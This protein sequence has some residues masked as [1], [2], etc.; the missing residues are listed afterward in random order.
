MSG[1]DDDKDY[2]MSYPGDQMI[3]A[4]LDLKIGKG[5]SIQGVDGD[6]KGRILKYLG[7]MIDCTRRRIELNEDCGRVDGCGE[8]K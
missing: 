4:G 6:N 7:I 5:E 8:R 3:P 2:R 1:P